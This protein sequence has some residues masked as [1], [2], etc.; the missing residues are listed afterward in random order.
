MTLDEIRGV[1]SFQRL[2]LPHERGQWEYVAFEDIREKDVIRAY[3]STGR[4][5]G[6]YRACA[7]YSPVGAGS[8]MVEAI[9][10]HTTVI[11]GQPEPDVKILERDSP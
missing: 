9:W 3:E 10:E 8:V 6:W 5:V 1:R 4:P 11:S 2:L 7:D